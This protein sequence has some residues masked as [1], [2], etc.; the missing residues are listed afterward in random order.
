MQYGTLPGIDKPISRLVQGTDMFCDP[1]EKEKAFALYDAVFEL[2]C[3]CM[4]TGHI[5]GGGWNERIV[6][7]WVNSRGHQDKMVILVKGAHHN[8]DR[9]RVTPFDIAADI[10]DSLARFK[11]DCLDLYILHRDDPSR[12][13]GPI[14]EALNEHK[15]AGRIKAFGGS[16]WTAQRIQEANDYAKARGMTPFVASSP[17]YSLAEQIDEPWGECVSISGP[18]GADQRAWYEEQQMAIFSWSSLARGF[19]SGQVSRSTADSYEDEMCR[20]CY[21]SDANFERLDRVEKMAADKGLTVAQLAFA[22]VMS[23]PLEMFPLVGCRSGEE[24]Q[25]NIDAMEVKLTPEEL[26]WLDLK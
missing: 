3:T 14:V 7:E 17:N 11:F 21:F 19:F 23:Q 20:R 4:D 6:G 15:A 2:G 9:R 12:P 13:V 24:Y 1:D 26:A 25:A 18:T 8:Q 5:Y 10:H 22:F 16:N